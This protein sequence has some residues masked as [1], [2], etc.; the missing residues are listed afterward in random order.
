MPTIV[1]H[2][3]MPPMRLWLF[4]FPFRLVMALPALATVYYAQH[5]IAT[6][7]EHAEGDSV[8]GTFEHAQAVLYLV[9]PSIFS[10]SCLF[11]PLLPP[12]CSR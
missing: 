11:Q 2:L 5:Y 4:T 10:N 7:T 9:L 1:A 12:C 3:S 6:R 8:G